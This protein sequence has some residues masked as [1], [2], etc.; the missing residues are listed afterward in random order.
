MAKKAAVVEK[1]AKPSSKKKKPSKKVLK[2]GLNKKDLLEVPE[3]CSAIILKPDGSCQIYVS[4][5]ADDADGAMEYKPH[6]ELAIAIGALLQNEAY[7]S[8]TINTFRELFD[9]AIQ[10]QSKPENSID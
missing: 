6:E 2:K 4:S 5:N 7:V 10:Q 9:A 3:D 8:T 1:E